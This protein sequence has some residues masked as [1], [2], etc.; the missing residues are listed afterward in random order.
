MRLRSYVEGYRLEIGRGGEVSHEDACGLA[1]LILLSPM[2]LDT[3]MDF[4]IP[5]RWERRAY[6]RSIEDLKKSYKES[7][8]EKQKV[9]K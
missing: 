3:A 5:G 9:E 2:I 7:Q 4:F 8:K 6:E 1:M